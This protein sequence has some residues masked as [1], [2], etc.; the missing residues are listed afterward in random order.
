MHTVIRRT[1]NSW[2]DYKSRHI[3]HFTPIWWGTNE[4]WTLHMSGS[5]LCTESE[6]HFRNVYTA[7]ILIL[8]NISYSFNNAALFLLYWITDLL[9]YAESFLLPFFLSAG[10][11][12][13]C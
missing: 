2:A 5:G 11:L 10:Q 3:D 6:K 1:V 9:L 13:W 12:I 7:G 8:C 4:I